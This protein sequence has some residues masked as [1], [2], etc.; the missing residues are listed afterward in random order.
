M[1][2]TVRAVEKAMSRMVLR[3]LNN[4]EHCH[5]EMGQRS[6]AFGK[7]AQWRGNRNR[8]LADKIQPFFFAKRVRVFS[9]LNFPMHLFELDMQSYSTVFPPTTGG[10]PSSIHSNKKKTRKEGLKIG[11]SL[12]TDMP[13]EISSMSIFLFGYVFIF[14]GSM[15]LSVSCN[16]SRQQ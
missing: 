1:L 13:G 6:E 7:S 16:H 15:L 3:S 12:Q 4:R 9:L 2:D 10:S 11:T 5:Q 14:L 8:I